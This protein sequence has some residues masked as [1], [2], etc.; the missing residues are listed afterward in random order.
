MQVQICIFKFEEKTIFKLIFILLLL[1]SNFILL[2]K[3]THT[4]LIQKI[5]EIYYFVLVN[6]YK[7]NVYNTLKKLKRVLV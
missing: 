7:I 2:K 5:I 3:F 1:Y 6:L 4:K